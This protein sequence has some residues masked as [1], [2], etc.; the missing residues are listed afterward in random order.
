MITIG[1]LATGSE[2]TPYFCLSLLHYRIYRLI[3]FSITFGYQL[4]KILRLNV[5]LSWKIIPIDMIYVP[6]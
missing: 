6:T 4:L 3:A 1:T 2:I 5:P